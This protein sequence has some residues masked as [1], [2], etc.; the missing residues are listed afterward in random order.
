MR[1][2]CGVIK[3][4]AVIV[5]LNMP[6]IEQKA[7]FDL[8]PQGFSNPSA[9]TPLVRHSKRIRSKS[10]SHPFR[11]SRSRFILDKF[12]NTFAST[13]GKFSPA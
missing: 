3:D 1:H 9:E 13:M 2:A 4:E 6:G 5:G 11:L 10:R 12:A 8:G 7:S